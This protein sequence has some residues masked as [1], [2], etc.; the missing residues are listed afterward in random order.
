MLV[1]TNLLQRIVTFGDYNM[2]KNPL[3]ISFAT[4]NL[5]KL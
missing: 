2:A 1:A 4:V 5:L 3:I